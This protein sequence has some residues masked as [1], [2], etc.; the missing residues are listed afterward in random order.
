MMLIVPIH[1]KQAPETIAAEAYAAS[2]LIRSSSI[3]IAA[4][5][6][7]RGVPQFQKSIFKGMGCRRVAG[8]RQ[9]GR[10]PVSFDCRSVF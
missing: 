3:P 4:E 7:A 8:R 1:L 9:P 6:D 2:I 5:E 10:R